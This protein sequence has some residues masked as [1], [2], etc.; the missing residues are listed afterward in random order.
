MF[1]A[2]ADDRLACAAVSSGNTENFATVP[3]YPPGSTDDA[4]Q[5]F[6]GA[7]PLA[8]DRWDTLWPFAPKPLLVSVSARDYFGTYSPSYEASRLEEFPKLAAAWKALDAADR[9]K[10]A[11]TP[12]P[13]GLSYDLRLQ[14]YNWFERWLKPSRTPRAI[15]EEPPTAPEAAETLWCGPTGNTIRDFHGKTPYALTAERARAIRTPDAIPD[16]R[17]LLA[18]D[19]P[20]ASPDGLRL[21]GR[22]KYRDCEVLGVEYHTTENV[23]CPA[24]LF[25][26]RKTADRFVLILE[27]NG[28]NGRWHEDDLYHQIASTGIAVCAAD[29]RGIGDLEPQFSPGAAG[30]ERSHQAEEDYAWAGLMLGK[31]LLGQRVADILGIIRATQS[32][33]SITVAARD[34]MTVPALCAAALEPRITRLYLCHGLS[35]WRSLVESETYNHPLANFIPN[36]L[37]ATDLPQISRSIAPRPV[38][39]GDAW[40]VAAIT[41]T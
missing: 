38:L 40:D 10:Y 35:S 3:F 13:H 27:P 8:F 30:Y 31:P 28:R 15:E 41:R 1:L 18:V 9:L 29:L 19:Q 24:W 21:C 12:L 20:P 37:A 26:P 11:D 6:V 36:V 23:Y 4:E 25:L 5:D 2:A 7:A 17:K 33:Y 32:A 16:L 22:T 39:T 14:I 34:K